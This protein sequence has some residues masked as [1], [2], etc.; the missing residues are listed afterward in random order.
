MTGKKI[1]QFPC[2]FFGKYWELFGIILPECENNISNET[3]EMFLNHILK[4]FPQLTSQE[5]FANI[6]GTFP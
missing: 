3:L 2:Q 4:R 6:P 1:I 5:H